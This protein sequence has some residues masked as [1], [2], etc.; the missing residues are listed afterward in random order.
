M[1]PLFAIFISLSMLLQAVL[2]GNVLCLGEN[3]HVA[4]EPPHKALSI[5]TTPAATCD[6]SPVPALAAD[7]HGP[8]EDVGANEEVTASRRA[9]RFQTAPSSP[10]LDAALPEPCFVV[11]AASLA[12]HRI[13]SQSAPASLAVAHSAVLLI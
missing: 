1:N 11:I 4:I 6:D 3:G 13:K 5:R 7:H 9:P 8:C 12:C 10:V 2:G